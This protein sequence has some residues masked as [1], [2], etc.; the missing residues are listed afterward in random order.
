MDTRPTFTPACH[1]LIDRLSQ[2]LPYMKLRQPF[3]LEDHART[4]LKPA[5]KVVAL[6]PGACKELT[7]RGTRGIGFMDASFDMSNFLKDEI[8]KSLDNGTPVNAYQL[9]PTAM[10]HVFRHR[11]FGCAL[12]R[13]WAFEIIQY[14]LIKALMVN[15][16]TL[17]REH[18]QGEDQ[19]SF[20]AWVIQVK[21]E[22]GY[23]ME[24]GTNGTGT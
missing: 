19:Y 3:G 12:I 18:Q 11:S 2:M 6:H 13:D 8:A 7:W 9:L 1:T 10:P 15:R 20:A 16:I 14:G 22:H 24:R 5:N 4:F 17:Q 21:E 23:L